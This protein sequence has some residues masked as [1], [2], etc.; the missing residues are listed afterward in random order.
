MRFSFVI[1]ALNEEKLIADCI[2]SIKPQL[3]KEDEIIVVDNDSKDLTATIAKKLGCRVVKEKEKGISP[4][5]NRGAREA[6]GDILCFVD[7]DGTLSKNWLN[8][9]RKSFKKNSVVAVDGLIV[10]SH[11]N[12]LKMILYNVY[13]AIIYLGLVLSKF[14]L[15]KHFFT[16][17]NMAIKK[18]IFNKLGGFEPFVSEQ[19]YLS[20]K[21]WNLK[22][23]RGV[24]NPK[25]IIFQSSRGFDEVGYIK[26]ILFWAVSAIKKRSSKNYNFER[27]W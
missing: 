4:A 1:P 2:N 17:N 5:R 8:E 19:M 21:F 12:P 27:K 13:T 16:G 3:A 22:K 11:K 24:L 20:K 15:K 25:M 26:T 23:G 10:F 6:R 9:A 18:E 7:A 14:L